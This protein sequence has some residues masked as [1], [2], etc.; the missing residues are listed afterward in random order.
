M[1]GRGWVRSHEE[2]ADDNTDQGHADGSHQ[3]RL[4]GMTLLHP[5]RVAARGRLAE[6]QYILLRTGRRL[7]DMSRLKPLFSLHW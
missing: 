5:V 4:V 2:L 3:P 7:L 6:T 1:P